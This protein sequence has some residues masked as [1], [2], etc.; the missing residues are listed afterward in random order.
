MRGTEPHKHSRGCQQKA[1]G[2]HKAAKWSS[3]ISTFP[4]PHP[5]F[6]QALPST[7][8]PDHISPFLKLCANAFSS[9]KPS[10]KSHLQRIFSSSGPQS[11]LAVP[12]ESTGQFSSQVTKPDVQA[13]SPLQHG[14]VPEDATCPRH[15]LNLSRGSA[16]RLPECAHNKLVLGQ[17]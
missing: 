11:A 1:P 17:E 16:Y 12:L 6:A 8:F 15:T 10:L 7:G 2:A 5:V 13:F 4:P 14:K 9:R 3:A